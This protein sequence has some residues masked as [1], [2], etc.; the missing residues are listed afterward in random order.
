MVRLLVYLVLQGDKSLPAATYLGTYLLT[1]FLLNGSIKL[2]N[3]DHAKMSF[4]AIK[5][6]LWRP[7]MLSGLFLRSV[8]DVFLDLSDCVDKLKSLTE[9]TKK[10]SLD[11]LT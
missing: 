4:K 9:V 3:L 1:Y 11:L 5:K 7:I 8:V 2:Q 6:P 10:R